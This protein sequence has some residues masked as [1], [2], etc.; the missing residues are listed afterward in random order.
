MNDATSL[1]PLSPIN[2]S[3]MKSRVVMPS[4]GNFTTADSYSRKQWRRVQHVPNKFWNNQKQNCQVGD[5]VLLRQEADW[6][7]WPM[8][9]IVNAYSDSKGNVRSVR[10]LL[11]ASDKSENSTRY[12]E[13]P[14]N[15]LIVLVENNN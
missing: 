15:K 8:A 12:L 3:T 2:L 14:V 6:N 9:Q 7:H 4:P 11:G 10:L 1:P 5:I 13:R